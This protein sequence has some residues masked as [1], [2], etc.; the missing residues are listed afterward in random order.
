MYLRTIAASALDDPMPVLKLLENISFDP[1][2]IKTITS[3]YEKALHRL[4]L[5]DTD[6]PT[7]ALAK[8]IIAVAQ[9][10]EQDADRLCE[11]ALLE[12]CAS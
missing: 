12:L 11:L 6:P 1:E 2:Q 8:H 3:A 4:R 7:E 5:R 10:G 9:N